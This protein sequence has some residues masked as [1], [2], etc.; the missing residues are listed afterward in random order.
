MAD[1][2]WTV[3][4]AI[5]LAAL[6]ACNRSAP[7]ES[8]AEPSVPVIAEPVRL[9]I[10]RARISATGVVGTLPGANFAVIAQQPAR[11]AEI[12]KNVGD[13]VKSGELLVQFEFPSLR[14]QT[15]VNTAA[16]RAADLRLQQATLVQERIRSLLARGA[17]SQREMDDADRD[18]T[19]AE[20]EMAAA[21]AAASATEALGQNTAIRAPFN[22]TVVER[23]HNA[24]DLVRPDDDDP[25]LRLIDPKQ[26][27]VTATVPVADIT[28]FAVG[29][30][31]RAIAEG[32]ATSD[33]LRVVSR[34][35]PEARATTVAV[36]LA[37]DT[38]TEL[39]PGTQ[40]GVEIDG[41]PRSNVPIVPAIA[42]LK[43]GNDTVV[44]V[45]AGTIA[46]RRTVVTGLVDGEHV[47]I[48]SGLRAG[49]LIVTQGHSSLRDGTPISVTT[50]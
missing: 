43:D 5:A 3:V 9:G 40:V 26:V 1:S 19:L 24:G 14:A 45:A 4:L 28:R 47:E 21:R 10:I 18:V 25:I 13:A 30:T 7:R 22:G 38:P 50:P 15:A 27:Q 20:G 33:L 48:R 44:V 31:A 41:E 32:R 37:F 6:P 39:T 2:R 12:T 46:Q 23:L 34:P 16:A 11:I 49:E 29:A 36:S 8:E 42:V 35:E 17:A